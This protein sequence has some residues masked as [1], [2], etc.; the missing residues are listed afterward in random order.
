MAGNSFSTK[1]ISAS[2]VWSES[3]NRIDPC[4]NWNGTPIAR[5]T[6]DGSNDPDVHAEPDEAQTPKSFKYIKIDSPSMYP[7]LILVVLGTR[8]AGSPFTLTSGTEA[9]IPFSN[10][11]RNAAIFWEVPSAKRFCASSDALPSPTI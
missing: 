1:S 4:A 9:K 2:V 8:W 10:L 6:C 5:S 3:E 11:S 7:K